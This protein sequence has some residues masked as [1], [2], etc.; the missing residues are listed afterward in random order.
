MGRIPPS[1]GVARSCQCESLDPCTY[2][3]YPAVN[4]ALFQDRLTNDHHPTLYTVVYWSKSCPLPR[5][6]ATELPLFQL[7]PIALACNQRC[8][9]FLTSLLTHPTSTFFPRLED[10]E[11]VPRPAHAQGPCVAGESL[12]YDLAFAARTNQEVLRTRLRDSP[13]IPLNDAVPRPLNLCKPGSCEP[14]RRDPELQRLRPGMQLRGSYW[15]GCTASYGNV[16]WR[17]PCVLCDCSYSQLWTIYAS[18]G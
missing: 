9:Q 4:D 3:R 1:A 12:R 8:T 17:F 2:D 14:L 6:P 5:Y 15:M 16:G 18:L 10:L 13:P 7:S 11:S